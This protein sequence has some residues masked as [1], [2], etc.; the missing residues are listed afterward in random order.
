MGKSMKI[1]ICGKSHWISRNGHG[2]QFAMSVI[3]SIPGWVHGI[4]WRWNMM[5]PATCDHRPG[6]VFLVPCELWSS[7][8]S[9]QSKDGMYNKSKKISWT[10]AG[11]WCISIYHPTL[12][13]QNQGF[14]I[15]FPVLTACWPYLDPRPSEG[16]ASKTFKIAVYMRKLRQ[17]N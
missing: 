15:V 10:R 2:F 13:H 9:Q 6:Q 5:K 12:D 1:T 14:S 3:V 11:F 7:I 8:P 16:D 17:G 4:S